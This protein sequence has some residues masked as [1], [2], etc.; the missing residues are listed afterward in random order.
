MLESLDVLRHFSLGEVA[1][2]LVS[3]HMSIHMGWPVFAIRRDAQYG[4]AFGLK[5]IK[6]NS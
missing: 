4:S 6:F 5:D 2:L 1:F 3:Q